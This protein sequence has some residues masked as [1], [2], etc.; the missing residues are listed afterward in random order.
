MAAYSDLNTV[1]IDATFKARVKEATII[2]AQ[3]ILAATGTLGDA[4]VGPR[5]RLARGVISNP[6]PT[7]DE[8]VDLLI[9]K[10]NASSTATILAVTDATMQ[11]EVDAIF[12]S[13]AS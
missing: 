8:M 6:Q 1:R 13:L 5:L 11:T 3:K 9:A 2:A 4:S 10:F 12:P 7:A